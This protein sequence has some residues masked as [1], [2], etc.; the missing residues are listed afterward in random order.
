MGHRL[1]L[2]TIVELARL[3]NARRSAES[4]RISQS[5]VSEVLARLERSYGSRLFDRGRHGSRPTATGALVVDAARRA[6]EIL[7][8]AEREIGLLEG[9]QRGALSVAAH[10]CLIETHL[11]PAVAAVLRGN[12]T[13]H[14]QM[15]SA[16]PDTLLDW[17]RRQQLEFYVGFE[18]DGPCED[19]AIER[20]DTYQPVPFCRSGHPLASVP[21]QGIKVLRQYPIVTVDVPRWYASR[22]DQMGAD[23]D[24]VGEIE[25]RGRRVNVAHLATMEAFVATTDA[26]GFAPREA[27]RA[28]VDAGTFVILD[29]PDDE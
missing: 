23:P 10:P 4:L 29:V 16:P 15:H 3:G 24:V 12:L 9:F 1:E 22:T 28:G 2:R 18:P 17:L 5:T 8:N 26:L 13:L 27:I 7:D 21:P 25:R 11:A 14:C 6:L 19:V 20:I